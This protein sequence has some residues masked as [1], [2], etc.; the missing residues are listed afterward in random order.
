[1]DRVRRAVCDP[2]AGAPKDGTRILI[3]TRV[4]RYCW[5]RLQW[6]ED[7]TKWLE[8]WWAEDHN[9]L[10]GWHVWT[11]NRRGRSTERLYPIDWARRPPDKGIEA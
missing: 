10:E 8:G 3:R 7:G 9:D 6:V 5:R 1:M 4:F 11:G 2:M